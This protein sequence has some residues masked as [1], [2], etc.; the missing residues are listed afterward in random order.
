MLAQVLLV[1][2]DEFARG[3]ARMVIERAGFEVVE[4]EDVAGG[5]AAD[6]RNFS[7]VVTDW[8]LPDGHGGE[9]ARALHARSKELPVIL[10]TGDSDPA[11]YMPDGIIREFDSILRKP[12]SP[13]ALEKAIRNAIHC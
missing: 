6:S 1:D 12:Y 10:V 7:V 4:A 5:I 11:E 13:S 3:F 2:D 8:N 9:L